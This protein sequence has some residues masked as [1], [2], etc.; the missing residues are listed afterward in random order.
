MP[1][2]EERDP[3]R[4]DHSAGTPWQVRGRLPSFL[5]PFS[6][7][8]HRYLQEA[9]SQLNNRKWAQCPH[10]QPCKALAA[11]PGRPHRSCHPDGQEI[12]FPTTAARPALPRHTGVGPQSTP[13]LTSR[14]EAT[15][16]PCPRCLPLGCPPPRP[17]DMGKRPPDQRLPGEGTG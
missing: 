6:P 12:Q 13:S 7:R 14:P 17:S 4:L 5:Y 1:G 11:W 10:S 16:A 9:S 3:R 8:S 2:P 15:V